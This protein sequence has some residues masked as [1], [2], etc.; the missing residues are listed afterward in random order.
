MSSELIAEVGIFAASLVLDQA[1]VDDT[2]DFEHSSDE[3]SEEWLRQQAESVPLRPKDRVDRLDEVI[4]RWLT[5]ETEKSLQQPPTP[6]PPSQ[7]TDSRNSPAPISASN[8]PPPSVPQ[9]VVDFLLDK[10]TSNLPPSTSPAA[11][12]WNLLHSFMTDEKPPS[13]DEVKTSLDELQV[14][15]EWHAMRIRI[16]QVEPD[17][18]E[19][20]RMLLAQLEKMKPAEQ[21]VAE[22]EVDPKVNTSLEPL[23][24]D[25]EDDPTSEEHDELEGLAALVAHAAMLEDC[26]VF[27]VRCQQ[28]TESDIVQ[29]I[30]RDSCN[31]KAP[32]GLR[33]AF[34]SMLP[35]GLYIQ[36]TSMLQMHTQASSYF[37][38]IY[39]FK[40]PRKPIILHPSD[41]IVLPPSK[42]V[43]LLMPIPIH[44]RV[45]DASQLIEQR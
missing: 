30:Q 9:V 40:Y 36:M 17:D 24:L 32:P 13:G 1:E 12:A 29:R 15:E 18:A 2:L 11:R 23:L 28:G 3:D 37:R 43:H 6:A 38:T 44:H 10:I 14:G 7:S 8:V 16:M 19:A 45:V 39:G 27:Y 33:G 35:G 34:P 20:A 31:G 42:D 21:V 41:T 25:D 4:T 5:F 26:E 22:Q